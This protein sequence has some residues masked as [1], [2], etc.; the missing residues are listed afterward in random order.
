M[1]DA[2]SGVKDPPP[3]GSNPDA[4][5]IVGFPDA[6]GG[7]GGVDGGAGLDAGCALETID[8]LENGNFDSG[9]GVA[10]TE[11]SSGGLAIILEEGAD[12]FP[13][14]LQIPADSGTFLAY[15]AGYPSAVDSLQENV[16]LP[17]DATGVRLRGV[18]QIA[19]SETVDQ[20]F[21]NAFVE[22]QPPGG[23]DAEELA[24]FTNQDATAPGAYVEFEAR[25]NGDYRGQT[26][27]VQVRATTDASLNTHFFFDSL[28]LEVETCSGSIAAPR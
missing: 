4:A 19:T 14:T 24:R 3:P 11:Q 8:L 28:V 1:D 17:A 12:E 18:R 15:L 7:G 23:E 5:V 26:V 6:S 16:T 25:A 13:D 27:T 9:A 2:G 21:D 22:I 10:W 20:P